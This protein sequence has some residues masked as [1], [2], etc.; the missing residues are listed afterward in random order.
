MKLLVAVKR[1][2]DFNVK[3]RV[4]VDHS[5]VDI[6]NAKMSLNPFDEIALEEALRLK[7]AGVA[8]EVIAVSVGPMAC[9]ET[10]RTAL[11]L[12]ADKAILINSDTL[13]E[14]LNV[15][16][17]LKTIVQREI[18]QLVLLGKQSI[19]GDNN[20]TGQM[21]AALLDWP[22]ATFASQVI[23]QGQEIRVTCEVDGGLETLLLDLPA[24]ITV[25]LRLN[26]PRYATLPNIMKAKQKPLA[27]LSLTDLGLTLQPHS[28]ILQ[29]MPPVARQMGLKI[30]NVVELIAKLNE[31]GVIS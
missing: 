12:G 7:E 28:Q 5:D 8:T 14:P 30:A 17:I 22:Q 4:K 26:Q 24:V 3:V 27:V 11:A 23:V 2:V 25:D 13:W 15:A 1:V 29:V 9:Q 10:L 20:Q 19:D 31:Q 18:P 16:K 21:L 6:A